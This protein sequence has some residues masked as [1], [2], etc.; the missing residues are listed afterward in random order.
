MHIHR[1]KIIS[2]WSEKMSLKSDRLELGFSIDIGLGLH[3]HVCSCY[4]YASS[5]SSGETV[6]M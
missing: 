3:L 5:E 2:I 4:I 1:Q 6:R